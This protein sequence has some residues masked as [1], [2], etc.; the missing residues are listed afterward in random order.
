LW[1][2]KPG[3]LVGD[4]NHL[5]KYEFVSWDH[6]SQL[7]GKNKIH[8]P[9]HQPVCHKY[10]FSINMGIFGNIYLKKIDD[11]DIPYLWKTIVIHG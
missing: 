1:Y 3:I 4:F 2:R 6:Y 9:N 11:I 7:N 8:V 5:E 10:E